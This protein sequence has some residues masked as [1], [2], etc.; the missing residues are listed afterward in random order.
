MPWRGSA[1]H[2]LIE[3]LQVYGVH[4]EIT[5]SELHGIDGILDRG[6]DGRH[7]DKRPG[8]CMTISRFG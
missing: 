7:D 2:C 1:I 8:K 4:D 3:S 6:V 5:G